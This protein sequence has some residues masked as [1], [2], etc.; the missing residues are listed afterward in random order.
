MPAHRISKMVLLIASWV[1]FVSSGVLAG[2]DFLIPGISSLLLLPSYAFILFTLVFRWKKAALLAIYAPLVLLFIALCYASLLWSDD[3]Y[4]SLIEATRLLVHFLTAVCVV[5]WIG[6]RRGLHVTF[7]VLTIGCL[8]SVLAATRPDLSYGEF[9]DFRGMYQ[10]KNILGFAAAMAAVYGAHGLIFAQSLVAS[11]VEVGAGFTVT[12]M[13]ESASSLVIVAAAS[14]TMLVLRS[15]SA[16]SHVGPRK[17]V[18]LFLLL[19]VVGY[20][21]SL[22]AD[23]IISTLGR[24]P[25][26]TGRTELWAEAARLISFRP[27]LGYGYQILANENGPLALS[28]VQRVGD[29]ALQFHNSLLNIRFQ[30]GMPGIAMNVAVLM[31]VFAIALGEAR[32]GDP[33][34]LVPLVT[35][36]GLCLVLQ[37]VSESTFGSPRSLQMFLLFMVLCIPGERRR[38]IEVSG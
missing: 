2:V 37:S 28:L 32:R 6:V 27:L 36:I 30:L 29:Y 31:Q 34:K 25:T 26:L 18:G 22:I 20:T 1:I 21:A 24:D 14:A 10:Q 33:Q 12:L 5:T 8:L 38:N 11:L 15:V 7:F 4:T 19:I 13:T 3:P 9:G 35:V 16:R 17:L 23:T